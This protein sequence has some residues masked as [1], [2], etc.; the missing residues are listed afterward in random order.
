[1][2]NP[3]ASPVGAR[4]EERHDFTYFIEE[5]K[6]RLDIIQAAE[7][8]GINVNKNGQ[9]DCF[10]GHDEKTPSLKFYEG[11]QSYHCFGC[12]AH[13]DA[14]SLVQEVEGWPFMQAVN[15]LATEVGMEPCQSNN[16]FDPEVYGRVGDCLRVTA[17]IYHG[18]LEQDD[19]YLKQRG[20]SYSNAQRFLIGR[21]RCKDDLRLGLEARGVTAHTMLL[22]GLIKMDGTDFFQD[23][24]VVPIVSSG[25]VVN[26]YG[27]S[28]NDNAGQHHWRLPNDRFKVG[29]GLFNLGCRSKEVILVEGVF[30]ALALIENGFVNAVATLGTQG[31]N[32][33]LPLLRKR[34]IKKAF[35]CYDGDP[36]GSSAALST[37]YDLETPGIE[38][39]VVDIPAEEDPN[40]FFKDRTREDFQQ[41]LDSSLSPFDHELRHIG[42]IEAR[43]DQLKKIRDDL[44][45]RMKKADPI[46]QP[47]LIKKIHDQLDV[48]VR[49]LNEQL[50]RIEVA[51]QKHVDHAE[52]VEVGSL[53]TIYP[54]LDMVDE[55][56]IIM[57]RVR[58]LDA[59]TQV[60][61]WQN[62][63][64]SSTQERFMLTNEEL[65]K[66]GW[67]APALEGTDIRVAEERY[68]QEVINGF[69][70]GS[71]PGDLRR[72][73]S[74][75]RSIIQ[76]YIDF[77]DHR[78]YDFL[79]CWIIGT[80]FYPIFSHYPYV[81]FTG[82]KGSGKSQCLHV[83]RCL[84]H[85]AIAHPGHS[86][87]SSQSH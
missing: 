71:L 40:S 7:L 82:P 57:A 67:Y 51:P 60:P 50:K 63:V 65:L 39:R 38:A 76:H 11:T 13:G 20:V 74:E 62:T 56:M 35:V 23:H 8:H 80:Y 46:M 87:T 6:S 59:E 16:G 43:E 15:S 41:L 48:P 73:F 3:N 81:H 58:V 54:A 19:P 18:W 52:S 31:L 26:S 21:T 22:S 72:T 33:S 24:I 5:L 70:E 84:C 36:A 10:N 83:L 25:R 1:M 77:S 75:I 32:G 14:I 47:E 9:A 66:R 12:N 55:N 79:A 2:V 29:G 85:N 30:D 86:D 61:R 28:L 78:T 64:V 44:L 68:S 4:K 53:R 42:A 37:A 17:E 34:Q 49:A 27:R 45:P 69:L